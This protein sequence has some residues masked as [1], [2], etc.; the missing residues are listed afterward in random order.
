MN[1]LDLFPVPVGQAELER[2]L[3]KDEMDFIHGLKNNVRDNAANIMTVNQYVL[4]EEP[5]KQLK[6]ELESFVREYFHQVWS[7]ETN[8]DIDIYITSSWLTWTGQSEAHHDHKHPNSIVSGTFY[9]S[10]GP[11]DAIV[12]P[13]DRIHPGNIHIE[14]GESGVNIYNCQ[15]YV[16]NATTNQLKLFPATLRHHVMPKEDQFLRICL[17]FNTWVRGTIGSQDMSTELKL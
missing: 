2:S 9:V 17:A 13:N 16:E 15:N 11:E 7:P 3:T 5:L 4:D 6:S 8:S 1:I 10:G 12:F 14:S